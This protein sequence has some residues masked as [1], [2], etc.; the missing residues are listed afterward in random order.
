MESNQPILLPKIQGYVAMMVASSLLIR[1]FLVS[2]KEA[3]K[4]RQSICLSFDRLFVYNT[5]IIL[6]PKN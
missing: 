3:S 5:F 1:W 6:L 2:I 4:G